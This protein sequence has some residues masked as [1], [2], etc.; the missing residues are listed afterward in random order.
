MARISSSITA[1]GGSGGAGIAAWE[2]TAD[3][4][5]RDQRLRCARCGDVIGVYEPLVVIAPHGPRQ[6]SCAAEPELVRAREEVFHRACH[7][8]GMSAENSGARSA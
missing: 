5:E 4:R 8:P 3:G 2:P 7:A 1:G 6:A